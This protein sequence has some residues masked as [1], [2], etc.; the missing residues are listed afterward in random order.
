MVPSEGEVVFGSLCLPGT[1]IVTSLRMNRP[2]EYRTGKK[3]ISAAERQLRAVEL[4]KQGYGFQEIADQ[5]DYAGP[6]G[7]HKAVMAALRKTIQEPSDELR[8]LECERLDVMLKSLWPFVLKGSPRHVEQA[9]RVMDRRAAYLGLDAPKQ[10][11]DHRTVTVRIMAEQ[12]G[13]ELGLDADELI[14]EAERIVLAA[15]AEVVE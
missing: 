13:K 9:L 14:A 1:D 5:L 10:V 6:S 15:Q 8:K 3:Q 11:E 12:I 2:G 4:R 7:A